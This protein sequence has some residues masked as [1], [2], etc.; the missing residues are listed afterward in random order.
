VNLQNKFSNAFL[1]SQYAVCHQ[2]KHILKYSLPPFSN[3]Y[4]PISYR[5]VETTQETSFQ[6]VVDI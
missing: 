5:K 1:K 3:V 6:R 4:A 2:G